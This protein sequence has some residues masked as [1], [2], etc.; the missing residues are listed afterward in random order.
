MTGKEKVKLILPKVKP[1]DLIKDDK[2]I[3][4]PGDI[5]QVIGGETGYIGKQ[6]KVLD[7]VRKLN[8]VTLENVKLATKH[9]RPNPIMP[10]G[11]KIT[12]PMPIHFSNIKLV[13]PTVGKITDAKLKKE[14]NQ[15]TRRAEIFRILKESGTKLPVPI[16]DGPVDKYE[17]STLDTPKEAV[18][19]RTWTPSIFQIPFPARF[20]NQM[21]RLRRM[22]SGRGEF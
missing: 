5:V 21:E 20:M 16:D 8:S 15:T 19:E 17:S 3:F 11:G 2:W 4:F 9:V 14:I 12:K 7:V 6:A 18:L 1:R 22:N 10:Y 13:D